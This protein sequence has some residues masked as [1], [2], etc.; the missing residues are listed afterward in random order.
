MA[1]MTDRSAGTTTIRPF[2]VEF[3][4]ADLE[5]MRARIAAT[6]FPE[7][8]TVA[9]DSQ[10]VPLAPCRTIARY[11]RRVRLAATARR[12]LNALPN[13]ITEIDGLDIHFVH[14][15]LHSRERLARWSSARL[16]RLDRRAAEA[17]RPAHRSDRVRRQRRMPFTW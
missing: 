4:E 5:D 1:V 16:A 3:S 17:H 10:G 15:T 8:E 2:T 12:E 11:W 13:F 6:R 9:D 14:V 7:K